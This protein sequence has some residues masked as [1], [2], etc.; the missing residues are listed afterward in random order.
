MCPIQWQVLLYAEVINL[1]SQGSMAGFLYCAEKPYCPFIS[2]G[3]CRLSRM[4]DHLQ[5]IIIWGWN[6]REKYKVTEICEMDFGCE[7]RPEEM[8]NLVQVR[9]C[10]ATGESITVQASD[11]DLYAQDI[12]EGSEVF[13][14]DEKLKKALGNDCGGRRKI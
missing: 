2:D 14:I 5:G 8:R 3:S 10:S 9:L 6:M 13:W 4:S 12:I 1:I 11:A 7:G